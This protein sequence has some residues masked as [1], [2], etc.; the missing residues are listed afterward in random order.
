MS[1]T[2]E[3]LL[4]ATYPAFDPAKTK[5]HFAQSNGLEHPLDVFEAGHFDL[6]QSAQTKANFNRPYVASLIETRR[7][8]HWLYAG[9]FSVH[10]PPVMGADPYSDLMGLA[11]DP[12]LTYALT[13]VVQKADLVGRLTVRFRKPFRQN[14]PFYATAGDA[15]EV[16]SLLDAPRDTPRFRGYR[17]VRLSFGQLTRIIES[18]PEDWLTALSNVA[19]VYLIVADDGQQYVGSA[20]G[21]DGLW[22]RWKTYVETGGHGGNVALVEHLTA[23]PKAAAR[24]QFSVLEIADTTAS[25]QDVLDR[26]SHWKRVLGTRA[27]GLNLN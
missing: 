14:Y 11:R 25:V 8:H 13:P 26:E 15:L 24:F 22:D 18:A 6:W 16:S 23:K 4:R 27:T 10:G 17:D 7:K 12:C 5:L 2:L 21:A 19:G 1:L 9:L 20:T 3:T